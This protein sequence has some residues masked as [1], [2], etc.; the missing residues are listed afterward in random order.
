MYIEK[1]ENELQ[2]PQPF[3]RVNEKLEVDARD[4]FLSGIALYFGSSEPQN[5]DITIEIERLNLV[6]ITTGPNSPLPAN[7]LA[8]LD[9]RQ[10]WTCLDG[11][12][13]VIGA[14][15]EAGV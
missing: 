11:V 8:T 14:P 1:A 13:R 12:A 2:N 7:L 15:S 4:H 5:S 3:C 10:A 6:L 9:P